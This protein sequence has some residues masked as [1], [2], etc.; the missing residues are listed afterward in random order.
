ML[1]YRGGDRLID[2]RLRSVRVCF[3]RIN[4]RLPVRI[5]RC[6]GCGSSSVSFDF[7]DDG[8]GD[9]LGSRAGD[10]LLGD[11]GGGRVCCDV[12]NGEGRCQRRCRR[13][14]RGCAE[15]RAHHADERVLVERQ[16]G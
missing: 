7:G 5:R 11:G 8:R 15:G 13:R 3:P 9:S 16:R 10:A 1:R 6:R 14:R 4:D 2:V 12:L